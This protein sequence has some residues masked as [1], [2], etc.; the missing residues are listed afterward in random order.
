MIDI[1]TEATYLGCH[2]SVVA[3]GL[4]IGFSLFLLSEAFF[5]VGFF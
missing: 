4:T 1:I 5:F 2:T 3:R